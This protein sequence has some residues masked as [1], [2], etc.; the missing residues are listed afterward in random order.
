MWRTN[1]PL[2]I[3]SDGKAVLFASLPGAHPVLCACVGLS[4]TPW[5]TM[6]ICQQNLAPRYPEI[7]L[8]TVQWHNQLVLNF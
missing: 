5:R 8:D 1:S 4:G 2:K 7:C 3:I 6:C